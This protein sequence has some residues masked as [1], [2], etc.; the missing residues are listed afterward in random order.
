MI[1][2]VRWNGNPFSWHRISTGNVSVLLWNVGSGSFNLLS[3]LTFTTA[4]GKKPVFS[5]FSGINLT[6]R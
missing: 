2:G 4:E 3:S 6:C 5:T 1:K